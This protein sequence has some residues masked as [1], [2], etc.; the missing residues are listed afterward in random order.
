MTKVLVLYYSAY[1][2]IETMANAVAEGAREAGASVDIKRVPELVPAEVAKASYYKLDQ[3]APVAKVEDLFDDPHLN[4]SGALLDS[5]LPGDI[6]TKLPRLPI[7]I[8]THKLGLRR[9]A[10]RIGEHTGEVLGEIGI[11][12]DEVARLARAGVIRLDG[13]T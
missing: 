2:H 3:A 9:Q 11:D 8:G 13:T 5:I 6:H 10:P 12:V 7:E 4:A 1:G